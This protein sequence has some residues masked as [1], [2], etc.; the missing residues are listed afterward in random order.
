MSR[1]SGVPL[2]REAG[3]RYAAPRGLTAPDGTVELAW[4][5]DA[6]GLLTLHW[7]EHG[8]PPVPAIPGRTGMGTQLL[9]RQRGLKSVEVE[10]RPEGLACTICIEGVYPAAG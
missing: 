4:H 3:Q 8:G 10:F 2:E 6:D 9:R 7:R 1:G 5:C